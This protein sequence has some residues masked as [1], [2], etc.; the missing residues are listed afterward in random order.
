[1]APVR[2]MIVGAGSRGGSYAEW[3]RRHPH[4]AEV[5]AVAE[6][7]AEYREPLADA[8]GVPEAARFADWREAAARPR[9]ADAALVCTLD[10]AHLEPALA[11]ADRGYHLLVEKPLAQTRAECEA[12]VAAARRN[13]V[14]LGVCHV[15]RYAPYTRVLKDVVDSGRIGAI[16]SVD[17]VE[18]VG[19][20]HQAHS[21]VRGNWRRTDRAAPMLLAKSCHDLDWLRHIVGRD[22]VSVSSFGSL[23]HFRR[24]QAP[25]GA[26][27][28]CLDCAIEPGCA[29]SA[30]RIYGRFVAEGRTGWPLNVLTPEPTA[31]SVTEALRVGPY[32]RCVY[33]CDNDVV[34]HQV[35]ALEFAGG[36]TAT[37]TMSAFNR[38]RPRQTSVFG[39]LGEVYCD[40]DRISVYDFLSD[41]TEEIDVATV[42]DGLID[43]GHGGGDGGLLGSFLPAVA[44][45]DPSM[46][47]TSGEDAL[48]SH[49]LVFAA[50]QARVEGRV[51]ALAEHAV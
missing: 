47:A 10:D 38:A 17:H 13:D 32:G 3:I 50:E 30:P 16:V 41:T 39:T 49:V 25:A 21:Y 7:R 23:K 5:V 46:V 51:V 31:G 44:A 36:A 6:P 48:R 43:S 14:L 4:V 34:D 24:D 40:G 1:M 22:A 28:R 18:P 37:F 26:A 8:H 27:E 2:V 29:Y 11:L 33:S 45:G 9:L 20:W 12:I 15:L 42:N 19:F 35:V